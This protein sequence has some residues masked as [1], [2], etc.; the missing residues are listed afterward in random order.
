M[1]GALLKALSRDSSLELNLI[2]LSQIVRKVMNH[3][4]V[5]YFPE[6]LK[7]LNLV[8]SEVNATA[9]L[10]V[11]A[12]RLLDHTFT[13]INRYALW[14]GYCTFGTLFGKLDNTI[15]TFEGFTTA[16][17]RVI[18]NYAKVFVKIGDFTSALN[19]KQ[20]NPM[21]KAVGEIFGMVFDFQVPEDII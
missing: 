8:I 10:P 6:V 13:F 20:C 16:F 12:L 4:C 5:M 3:K 21:A 18:M 14:Q 19:N 1:T 17:Y 7:Q 9:L 11:N 15:E 2:Q